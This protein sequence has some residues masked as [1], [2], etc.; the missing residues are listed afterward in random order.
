M[1][2]KKRC[3]NEGTDGPWVR[4]PFR[5]GR[6]KSRPEKTRKNKARKDKKGRRREQEREV[7]ELTGKGLRSQ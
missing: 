4:A 7:A 2:G 3:I 5:A 1:E 6:G